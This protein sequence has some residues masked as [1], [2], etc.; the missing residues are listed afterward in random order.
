LLKTNA[1]GT[2][3]AAVAGTDYVT[4]SGLSGYVP[5]SRTITINGTSQSLVADSSY[6]VGTLRGNGVSGRIPFY[7][8]TQTFSNS[9]NFIWDDVNGYLGVNNTPQIPLDVL[10]AGFNV[11]GTNMN[12]V[13]RFTKD[14]SSTFKGIGL[15]YDTSS[16]TGII[17]ADTATT[18]IPSN[19]AF[20]TLGS[21]VYT[22]KMR[23]TGAGNVGIGTSTIGSDFKLAVY[24]SNSLMAFQNANTGQGNG[25]GFIVGSFGNVDAYLYNYENANIIMGTNATERMRITSGGNVGIG[26]SSPTQGKLQVENSGGDTLV[27]INNITTNGSGLYMTVYTS[28]SLV[29]SGR[30]LQDNSGGM[31]FYTGTTSDTERM[32]ITSG[33]ELYWNLTG[34]SGGSLNGGG[35]IFRNNSG[36][37]V[38]ISTGV[39]IDT[40]LIYFYKSDGAGSVTNTGSIATSGNLTL[41]NTTS[42]YRLKE[43]LQDYN[44]LNIISQL[45]TYDFKWKQSNV[46][47]YGMI[48]HE[49]QEI[50]PTYV[51]GQKDAIQQDGE[52]QLQQVDYSKIVPILVKSIQE[53]EARI[54]QLENK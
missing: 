18:S 4:P 53:L 9:S 13:A 46:R 44:A 22:E 19:I 47:D 3:V 36:K 37:Y 12:I 33:G 17:Y 43:D 42:D 5:T 23:I 6:T 40:G 31:R 14:K 45:K 30:I 54:K 24:G 2:I 8:G 15:G 16:Q 28:G 21:G 48:A 41:Y 25:D 29:S 51:Y 32:R 7:D 38:Q 27:N 49:L 26:T 1:S 50:L 20:W 10:G 11:S 39:T 34:A 52:I 35:V